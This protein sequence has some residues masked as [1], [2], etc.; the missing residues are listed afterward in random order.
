MS[1]A[2]PEMMIGKSKILA[3]LNAEEEKFVGNVEKAKKMLEKVLQ[4]RSQALNSKDLFTIYR[5]NGLPKEIIQSMCQKYKVEFN[6]DEFELERRR[7]IERS[8]S[9]WVKGRALH[10]PY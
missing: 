2:F 9:D 5:N 1:Q 7:H 3:I 8:K 10:I 4:I 6:D